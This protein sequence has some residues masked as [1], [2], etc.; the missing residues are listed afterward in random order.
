MALFPNTMAAQIC[1][2]ETSPWRVQAILKIRHVRRATA[3]FSI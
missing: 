2:P 3:A 1:R